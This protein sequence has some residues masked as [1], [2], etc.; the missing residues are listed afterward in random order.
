MISF[1][2]IDNLFIKLEKVYNNLYCKKYTIKK[3]RELKIGLG[4]FNVFYLEFIKLI[5]KFNF[6][7]EILL[8]KFIHKLSFCIQNQINFRLKYLDNIKDLAMYFQKIYDQILA[9]N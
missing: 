2:K 7:K 8:Q 4:F 1:E 5:A 9:I 3:F 6:I